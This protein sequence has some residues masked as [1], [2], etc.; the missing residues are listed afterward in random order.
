MKFLVDSALSPLLA[1][2]LSEAGHDAV[3]VRAYDMQTATD[4]EI[5]KRA[6]D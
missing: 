6:R 1:A 3:H 5:L 2:R 4:S